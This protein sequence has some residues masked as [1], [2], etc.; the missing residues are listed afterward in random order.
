MARSGAGAARDDGV[1]LI[2]NYIIHISTYIEKR[3]REIYIYPAC[4]YIYGIITV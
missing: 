3:E 2:I 4:W 1:L